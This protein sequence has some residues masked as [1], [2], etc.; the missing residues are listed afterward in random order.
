M[1]KEVIRGAE[2]YQLTAKGG[3]MKKL[4]IFLIFMVLC[5]FMAGVAFAG[6]KKPI[7]PSQKDK[8]PVCGMFVAKYPD[9]IAEIIFKDSSYAFFDGTKDMFN[10]YFNLEKYNPSKK[11]SE[12]DSIY[13][14]DY[15]NLNFIDGY[16]A[17]YVIGSDVY[18]PMGNE[19]IPVE[20]E[21]KAKE[22]MKDH[23]GKKILRFDE[24]CTG[25]IK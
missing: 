15:Y 13:V 5:L 6:E 2:N 17:Y 25:D 9:W 20:T 10:Y 1:K 21:S 3:N 18:G 19:L 14:K 16:S 12:I 8:C 22:F 24:V 23:R 4:Y 11:Q 7:K